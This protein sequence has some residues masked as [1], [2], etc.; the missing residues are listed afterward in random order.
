MHIHLEFKVQ[1]CKV[2]MS[3]NYVFSYEWKNIHVLS[4]CN[5]VLHFPLCTKMLPSL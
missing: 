3:E 5:Y 2:E 4:L 1:V